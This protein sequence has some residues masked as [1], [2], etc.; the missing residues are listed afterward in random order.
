MTVY[1]DDTLIDEEKLSE[2]V[3]S[4]I[5]PNVENEEHKCNLYA[6]IWKTED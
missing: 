5:C 4:V 3:E 6:I 2:A 1:Y